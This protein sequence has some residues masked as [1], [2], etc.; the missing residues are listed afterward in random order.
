M[1]SRTGTRAAKV[2]E[3]VREREF[4]GVNA[5]VGAPQDPRN[6][7]GGKRAQAANGLHMIGDSALD[8]Q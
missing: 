6:R 3:A 7:D 4:D 1:R 8:H 2:D 5:D